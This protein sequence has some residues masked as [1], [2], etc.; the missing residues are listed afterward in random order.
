MTV[1]RS[2]RE[3]RRILT[4]QAV[5]HPADHRYRSRNP[6]RAGN[7]RRPCR[8]PSRWTAGLS[9]LPPRRLIRKSSTYSDF[10]GGSRRW[11]SRSARTTPTVDQA[12]HGRVI[13]LGDGF[14]RNQCL[15]HQPRDATGLFARMSSQ[16]TL[17]EVRT[18]RWPDAVSHPPMMRIQSL[19]VDDDRNRGGNVAA[20]Y[21]AS[22]ATQGLSADPAGHEPATTAGSSTR[23]PARDR[24]SSSLPALPL[25]LLA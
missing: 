21:D 16:A 5:A 14:W 10:S 1:F 19:Q 15:K 11:L 13:R 18:S 9:F 6:A 8:S 2:E 7:L 17:I 12:R 4:L 3:P 24:N 23:C 22:T 20:D 25:R